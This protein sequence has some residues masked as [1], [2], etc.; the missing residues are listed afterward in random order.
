MDAEELI[1]EYLA[2]KE[3]HTNNETVDWQ[4]YMEPFTRRKVWYNQ[5]LDWDIFCG[6]DDPLTDTKLLFELTSIP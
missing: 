1:D 2:E 4:F 6:H 3:N 5:E